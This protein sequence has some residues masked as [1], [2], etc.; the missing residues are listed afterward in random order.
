MLIFF[1]LLLLLNQTQD[2]DSTLR[3]SKTNV[4]GKWL[5]VT[6][7]KREWLKWFASIF[8]G[9]QVRWESISLST[10]KNMFNSRRLPSACRVPHGLARLLL[11]FKSLGTSPAFLCGDPCRHISPVMHLEPN[12]KEICQGSVL[13]AIPGTCQ[14]ETDLGFHVMFCILFGI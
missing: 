14:E 13:D 9:F 10:V 7:V 11:L 3:K 1:L 12:L 5:W 8:W 6:R 2:N 4:G